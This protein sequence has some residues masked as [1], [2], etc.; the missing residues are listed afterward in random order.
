MVH[1]LHDRR[2]PKCSSHDTALVRY[3]QRPCGVAREL[4]RSAPPRG[5]A[6]TQ[7][8]S[9]KELPM[10]ANRM[11]KWA[12][13]GA[14]AVAGIPALGFAR[15]QVSLPAAVTSTP[16]ELVLATTAA[17]V[18]LAAAKAKPKKA[19]AHKRTARKHRA[20]RKS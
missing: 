5:G 8:K 3:I 15:S 12:A 4:T 11:L 2:E 13:A 14:L 20:V 10:T 1:L 19:I 17:P 6:A 16:T 9:A 18:K 7:R